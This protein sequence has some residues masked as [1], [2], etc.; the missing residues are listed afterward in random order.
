[1]E[2]ATFLLRCLN[3]RHDMR[4]APGQS[5]VVGR[6]ELADI[7]LPYPAVSRRQFRLTNEGGR[8]I[9]RDLFARSGTC[10]NGHYIRDDDPQELVAGD[11]VDFC[12]LLFVVETELAGH[13]DQ[14]PH[15]NGQHERD[16]Q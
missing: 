4:L 15:D 7:V 6:G 5:L 14:Q 11:H 3:A 1:M 10:V 13:A 8:L 2:P 16:G 12:E 9:I